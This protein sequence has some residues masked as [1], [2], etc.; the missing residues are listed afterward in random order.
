M[1]GNLFGVAFMTSL[2]SYIITD[3]SSN[4][5]VYRITEVSDYIYVMVPRLNLLYM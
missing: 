3:P 2:L 5:I 1:C 4:V